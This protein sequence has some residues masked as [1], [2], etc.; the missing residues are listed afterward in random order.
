MATLETMQP[1]QSQ[2]AEQT[3]TTTTTYK[4]ETTYAGN[5]G[6]DLGISTAGYRSGKHNPDEWH[7]ANYKISYQSSIDRD[8]AVK[9]ATTIVNIWGLLIY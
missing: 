5:T 7:S 1:G 3:S 9:V 8:G 6:N 4:Y 2:T